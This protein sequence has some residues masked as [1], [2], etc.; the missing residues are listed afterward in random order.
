MKTLK[1]TIVELNKRLIA[2]ES[3]SVHLVCDIVGH[4]LLLCTER[5]SE[6]G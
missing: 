4:L 2:L 1:T 5:G 3:V 6:P